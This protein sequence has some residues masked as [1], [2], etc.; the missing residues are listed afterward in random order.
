MIEM[1]LAYLEQTPPLINAMKQSF[2]EKDWH[3]LHGAVHKMIPSFLIMGMSTDFE[4]M[5]KKVLEYARTQE[6]TEG[7]P[8]FVLQLETICVQACEELREELNDIK[9]KK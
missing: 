1:I 7:I 5:A 8:H 6:Q 3:G 9:N 4:N 2:S